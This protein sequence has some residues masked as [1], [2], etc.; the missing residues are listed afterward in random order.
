MFKTLHRFAL[1]APL[2]LGAAHA[3]PVLTETY[4]NISTPVIFGGGNVNGNFTITTF[5]NLE[6]ALRAKNYGGDTIDGSSGIYHTGPG[7]SPLNAN[8]AVWNYEFAI[9]SAGNAPL[10]KYIFR[11]GV[12]HDAGLGT[13]FTYVDPLTYFTDNATSSAANGV[14]VAQ[15]SE[16]V[17]FGSTPGGAFDLST[18]GTYDF[19]LSAYRFGTTDFALANAVSSV[20][21]QVQVPEPASIA[22][23][24]LGFAGLLLA[25]RRYAGNA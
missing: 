13:N 5:N 18:A 20:D 12:D 16:N 25:R 4:G 14:H 2:F 9:S 19:V 6:L 11:L 22:L 1:L 21:L 3:A 24:G 7:T 17:I 15:N 10:S 23:L 8:R